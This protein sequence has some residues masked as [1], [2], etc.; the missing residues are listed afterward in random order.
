ME[1][2]LGREARYHAWGGVWSLERGRRDVQ[3]LYDRFPT[4][5]GKVGH[6]GNSFPLVGYVLVARKADDRPL[7]S[8]GSCPLCLPLKFLCPGGE[9]LGW[10]SQGSNRCV[11]IHPDLPTDVIILE[12]REEVD[13][14]SKAGYRSPLQLFFPDR[15]L[16]QMA[17]SEM[18]RCAGGQ[19]AVRMGPGFCSLS[20]MTF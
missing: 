3:N 20:P 1:S 5:P 17:T 12:S 18:G 19:V 10:D 4:L 6:E 11:H 16:N 13:L 7:G 2:F 14:R 8:Q 15:C 9:P